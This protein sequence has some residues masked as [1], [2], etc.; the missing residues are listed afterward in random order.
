MV[1]SDRENKPAAGSGLV[2]GASTCASRRRVKQR[3][4]LGGTCDER[5]GLVG[6][7]PLAEGR[8]LAIGAQFTPGSSGRSLRYDSVRRQAAILASN[9]FTTRRARA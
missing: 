2:S 1:R 3:T 9:S 7:L 5:S 6:I 4:L 8:R